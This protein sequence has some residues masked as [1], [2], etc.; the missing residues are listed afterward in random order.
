MNVQKKKKQTRYASKI[1]GTDYLMSSLE[2]EL[3]FIETVRCKD[4]KKKNKK[5][6]PIAM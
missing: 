6:S 3:R 2:Y 4:R 5:T 1:R